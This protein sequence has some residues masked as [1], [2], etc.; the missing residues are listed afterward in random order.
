MQVKLTHEIFQICSMKITVDFALKSHP[1]YYAGLARQISKAKVRVREM[2]LEALISEQFLLNA[3][4]DYPLGA[5][6]ANADGVDVGDSYWMRA[7]PVHLVLQRDSFSLGD[8]VPLTISPEHAVQLITVLNTHFTQDGLMFCLGQSGAW[9]LRWLS[10]PD[11]RTHLPES[12]IGRNVHSFMPQGSAAGKWR[13]MLNEIQMLLF[14]HPL[15]LER[16]AAGGHAVNSIW[17]SGGGVMPLAP[18]LPDPVLLVGNSALYRGLAKWAGLNCQQASSVEVL[19]EHSDQD[20]RLY[21]DA[22][23]DA[24]ATNL[25][26]EALFQALK[27]RKIKQMVFNI[28][29]FDKCLIAEM[30]PW[31]L[32]RFW[33]NNH[34]LESLVA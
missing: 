32:Y 26:F 5:I 6:A 29:F 33:R 3:E 7:D 16:E 10:R 15:N 8:P 31:D 28:G 11:I 24:S 34:A 14:E 12:A 22:N 18:H 20:I 2:P 13:T 30:V 21:L 27:S 19:L 25:W 23:M 1:Q 17:I 4:P 9:Y